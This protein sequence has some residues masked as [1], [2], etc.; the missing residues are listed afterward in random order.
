MGG[1]FISYRRSDSRGSA[2]RLYDN[3]EDRFGCD[4]VFRDLDALEPGAQYEEAIERFVQ[5]CDAV[6]A[7]I[8]NQW[9][10]ARDEQGRRRIDDPADLVRRELE[11]AIEHEKL[12]I[13]VLVEDAAMPRA[14][15]LPGRLAGL[16]GRNALPV[17][18]TRWDYDVG[19]LVE[20]LERALG[21]APKGSRRRAPEG[22]QQP[23]VATVPDG[24]RWATS[25]PAP[26]TAPPNRTRTVALV[27]V[28]VV[29]AL[30]LALSMA[31]GGS[32]EASLSLSVS[33][34]APG[35]A[36]TLSGS[37]FEPGE[38]VWVAVDGENPDETAA[39]DD[40]D[41]SVPFTVP[42]ETRTGEYTV[43]A[44]GAESGRMATAT[45]T[46]R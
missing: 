37:G 38:S 24:A 13:P 5:S 45:L 40:G 26:A 3:L 29:V 46:V 25:A 44:E 1:V 11:A 39:D 14:D 41:I 43:A 4:R 36:V 42:S 17:S 31:G 12:V 21:P 33:E 2:G 23:P 15:E 8:G 19:R 20:V 28:G 7:V 34:A 32:P 18:D 10:D 35:T 30:V 16:A 22:G 9:L 6:V 27:A